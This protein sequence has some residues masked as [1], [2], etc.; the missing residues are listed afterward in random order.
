[1]SPESNA[2][3]YLEA[4]SAVQS[5]I[6]GLKLLIAKTEA[7]M[8]TQRPSASADELQRAYFNEMLELLFARTA[9]TL[10]KVLSTVQPVSFRR[11]LRDDT[12]RV[13]RRLAPTIL[14]ESDLCRTELVDDFFAKLAR[15]LNE[16]ERSAACPQV[17]A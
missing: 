8:K 15:F 2:S 17:A 7:E 1:M 12:L 9:D 3:L 10:G 4:S 14:V 16:V 6:H 5:L 13:I 11:E